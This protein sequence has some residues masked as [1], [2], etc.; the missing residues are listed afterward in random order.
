MTKAAEVDIGKLLSAAAED[1]TYDDEDFE[2]E[3]VARAKNAKPKSKAEILSLSAQQVQREERA[4]VVAALKE[5]AEEINK[6]VVLPA[7]NDLSFDE[8]LKQVSR[9]VHRSYDEDND[10][11]DDE[12]RPLNTQLMIACYNNDK[13]SV[14]DLL[15]KS[16]NVKARDLHGWTPLIHAC[17]KGCDEI[18]I[19]LLDSIKNKDEKLKYIN[20]ADKIA[21]FTALHVSCIGTHIKCAKLLLQLGADVEKQNLVKERPIDC[22][23]N[24]NSYNSKSL[25][26]LLE[27]NEDDQ[28]ESRK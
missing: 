10:D 5:G 14:Q 3:F 17:S 6:Q 13:R 11:A 25:R 20:K 16:A 22:I 1:E 21:G 18:A 24:D 19:L 7:Q 12:E 2:D 8:A 4:E 23:K 15:H 27:S 26:L 28:K 9:E